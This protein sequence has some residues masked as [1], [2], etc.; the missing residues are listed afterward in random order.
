METRTI[1]AE[2][3]H[4]FRAYLMQEEKSAATVEKYLRDSC[5]FSAFAAGRG[6]TK[7]LTVAYKQYLLESGYAVRSVNSMLASL[8]S[9]LAFLGWPECRVKA[10]KQQKQI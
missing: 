9:L 7:E 4:S 2:Q 8:N 1:T 10:I 6:I 5:T 3:L